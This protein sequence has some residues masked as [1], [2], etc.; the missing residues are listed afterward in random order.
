M[1][2]GICNKIKTS[3][4]RKEKLIELMIG[5]NNISNLIF[6]EQADLF[7]ICIKNSIEFSY[8]T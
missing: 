5:I 6:S 1:S 7:T 4:S 3:N 8:I 2:I